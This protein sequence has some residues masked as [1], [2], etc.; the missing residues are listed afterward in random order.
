[1]YRFP[2]LATQEQIQM[3]APVQNGIEQPIVALTFE[4]MG[5]NTLMT[6]AHANLSDHELAE[7]HEKVW[8]YF[9]EISCEQFGAGSR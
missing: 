6:L 4:K 9:P 8:N 3:A 1:M 7:G 5:D 2:A